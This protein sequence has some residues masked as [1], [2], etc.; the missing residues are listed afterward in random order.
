MIP[1]AE[2][3]IDR[4]RAGER[5]N[6]KDRRHCIAYIIGTQPTVTNVEMAELFKVSER[7]IRIDRKSIRE[8]KSKLLKEEDIGLVIVDIA[9]RCE[10]QIRDIERSKQKCQ[11]G[12]RAYMEH[13]RAIFK[14]ELEK[15]SALQNLGYY[16]KNL[17]NMT[18]DKYEYKAIVSKDGSV[19]TR[20]VDLQIDG[21]KQQAIDV[22]YEVLEPLGLPPPAENEQFEDA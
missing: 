1:H 3:L 12:T 13:C 8:E 17:G 20:P 4:A 10:Q 21:G 11:L 16:P 14:I 6:P 19:N 18:I 5:L 9:M 7:Q 2:K 15:V 22:G